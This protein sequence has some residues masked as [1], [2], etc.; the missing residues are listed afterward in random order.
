HRCWPADARA[1]WRML[2]RR[3]L[4]ARP[5]GPHPD[6][7]PA[8]PLVRR[9]DRMIGSLFA[10]ALVGLGVLLV[11][12]GLI[13][14]RPPLAVTVARLTRPLALDPIGTSPDGNL[15]ARVGAPLTRLASDLGLNFGKLRRDLRIA[16][17]SIEAHV[18]TKV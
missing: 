1:G 10:G 9:G 12:R 3:V 11:W 15:T 18:A 14:S 2:R 13:P 16:G 7:G 8:H 6:P 4:A 17:R 5:D